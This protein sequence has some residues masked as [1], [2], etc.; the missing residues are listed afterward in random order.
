MKNILVSTSAIFLHFIKY[1][2]KNDFQFVWEKAGVLSNHWDSIGIMLGLSPKKLDEIEAKGKPPKACLHK[3]FDCWLKRDYDY[4]SRGVPTLRMLCN[5]IKSKSGGA[6][7]A[8]ADEITK[9]HSVSPSSSKEDTPLPS[10]ISFS[11][12]IYVIIKGKKRSG[13]LNKKDYMLMNKIKELETHFADSLIATK[14]CFELSL[15]PDIIEYIQYHIASLLSPRLKKQIEVQEE[16][17]HVRTIPD[18]FKI[19][20]KYISWFNF[21]FVEK[22]AQ[23]FVPGNKEILTMWSMYR[24]RLKDYFK[25]DNS[26]AV[27]VRDA[28]EF[29]VSDVPGTSVMIAKVARNDYTLNDLYFFHNAIADALEVPEY[30]FYFC[31]IDDGCMEL[32]YCIPDFLYSLLF[33][34][35]NQQC[36]SLAEIGIIK[37]TCGEYVHEPKKVCHRIL[38]LFITSSLQ[39]PDNKLKKL[40]HSVIG[41]LSCQYLLILFIF[42]T[43]IYD[44]L[45]Y[46]NTSTPLNKACW[47]GLKD[48]VQWLIDKIGY[49]SRGMNGWSPTLSGSYGGHI[50]VLQL[51]VD[52]YHCNPSQGDDDGVTSLHVASYKGH[53]NIVQYLVNECHVDPDRADSSGNI[54]L[55]YSALG[56]QVDLVTFFLKKKC[57]VSQVNREGSSL[58][59]LA[60]KSGRVALVR[61][62]KQFGLFS[63]DDQDY[64]GRGIV[65]YCAMSDSVELLEYLHVVGF[66]GKDRYGI[67]PLHIASQYASSAIIMRMISV[68]GYKVLLDTD[69]S[70]QS[71]LHYLCSGLIESYCVTEVYNK[72]FVPPDVPHLQQY[73]TFNRYFM[74]KETYSKFMKLN[75]N[76]SKWQDR[77]SLLSTLLKKTSSC[78][79]FNINSITATGQSLLHLACTSGSTLLVK[80]LEE[81]GINTS[82]LD[83]DGRSA[84][85]YAALS[86]SPTLL[87]Y[88]ASQYSM[89][90]S[91]PDYKGVVPLALACMSGSINAVEYLIN[92]TDIDSD[93][94]CDKGK[95][96]LHYSCRHGNLELSQYLIEVQGSDINIRDNKGWNALE[97]SARSG[98]M[99]LV[100]YLIKKNHLLLKSFCLLQAVR[101]TKLP[102][103]K[104]LVNEYKLDPQMISDGIQA[105]HYTANVG[106]ID[107]LQYII[108]DCGCDLN[109]VGSENNMNVF[110]YSA[111]HGHYSFIKYI[112]DHYPQYTSLLHSTNDTG[113]LP[114]HFACGC[115]VIQLVTFLIDVMKCDVTAEDKNGGTCVIWACMSGN[116]DLFKLLIKQYNRNPR[117]SG[118]VSSLVAAV[119]YGNIHIL[120]WLREEYRINVAMYQKGLITFAA[121]KL[122]HLY[123]LKHLLNNYSFD[124]NA[125]DLFDDSQSTLLHLACQEGHVATVLYLTSLPKYDISAKTSNGSTAL[126]LACKGCSLPILKHLVEECHMDLIIRDY[127][128]M[129]PVHVACEAGSLSLVKYLIEYSSLSLDITDSFG[130]TPLLIAALS[131]NLPIIRYLNSKNCNI[132]ILDDKGFNVIHVSAQ[133]GSLDILRF[134]IDGGY[135]NPDITDASNRT[136]LYLSVQEGHSEIVDY[137]LDSPSYLRPHVGFVDMPDSNGNTPLHAA[138]SRGHSNIVS[139]I[140]GA[141]KSLS[142]DIYTVN[143]NG[144]TP[145]HLAVANGHVNTVMSLLSAT[146]GTP[147]HE[148]LLTA[149]DGDGCS[150]LHLACQNGYY[151]MALYL[152]EVYPGNVYSLNNKEEG[153]LHA[154]AQSGNEDLVR[155]LVESHGLEP[156]SQDKDGVTCLHIIAKQ[157]DTELYKYLVPRVK[158]NPTPKDKTGRSP[159]HYA[160]RHYKMSLFLIQSFDCHPEDKDR[161]GFTGLHAACQTGNMELV[162]HYL[163]NMKCNSFLET[164]DSKGLLYFACLSGH[165]ELVRVLMTKFNLKPVQGDIDAAKSIKAE[166]IVSLLQR[167][168]YFMKLV[169][170]MINEAERRQL[171]PIATKAHPSFLSS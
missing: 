148:K 130:R 76:I 133:R 128:G 45:W 116:L 50:D 126:H 151:R 166:R 22:L 150:S 20:K 9:E 18:L 47:K 27:Q 85:H 16:F 153:L 26:K 100:Q 6:N 1:L 63:A 3:V 51:L 152:S 90:A 98:N 12:D 79:K 91:Q 83:Y 58:S 115:G 52:N 59:L 66:N 105:V 46:E 165:L 125:T 163:M 144:Q 10:P 33:P 137:L 170:E 21:G 84:V 61:Q 8:L 74:V 41:N 53:I 117:I 106:A 7:P 109:T 168:F 57:N 65:H 14:K 43:D 93:V 124:I 113:V 155:F 135:C 40:S 24:E 75:V 112:I 103:V 94:T 143:D 82:S 127:N 48:E 167:G 123:C 171:I 141:Y 118:G 68:Y 2:D 54:P 60:C 119:M 92:T 131:K 70:G 17:E 99:A 146:T 104:T 89:N 101:S 154:A 49:Q 55:L 4:K 42:Y 31:T 30:E 69:Y 157:G 129:A 121:A 134:F 138:C 11:N 114:I 88:T 149:V 72:L 145:L 147:T 81:Y 78:H 34:L 86:G 67:T 28:I 37:M 139:T 122:N 25:S 80:V 35:T 19:L 162:L 110:H 169:R 120:E 136:P 95:T 56:G 107:V 13:L 15:L 38:L 23:V 132:S 142:I 29:G 36:H 158:N 64:H 32:K 39:L 161:N 87:S 159:L 62:L 140:T 96:P 77:V 44:P 71:S 102:L 108:K 160:G 73:P 5:C 111:E 164:Y 97:H 156:E